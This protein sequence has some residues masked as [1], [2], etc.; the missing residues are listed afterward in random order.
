[1]VLTDPVKKR[2]PKSEKCPNQSIVIKQMQWIVGDF[3]Q[4]KVLEE[5]DLEL[6]NS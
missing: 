3:I 1:M 2:S 4:D 6:A 5:N